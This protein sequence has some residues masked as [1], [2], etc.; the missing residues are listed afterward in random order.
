M[1]NPVLKS[2]A[3]FIP[4]LAALVLFIS[5]AVESFAGSLFMVGGWI[6]G[7]TGEHKAYVYIYSNESDY[8]N[9]IAAKSF[10][11]FPE[12]VKESKAQY[13]FSMS[14]GEY[15]IHVFEDKNG[16]KKLNRGGYFNSPSEPYGY[17][18][19]YRPFLSS[20]SF[21]KLK[22]KLDREIKN[23]NINLIKN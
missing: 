23:A 11:I 20:P 15:L 16:D 13:R 22:F 8:K 4:L 2:F 6:R 21:E 10:I 14:A 9:G 7:L 12:N 3:F 5:C 19:R 1:K 18:K 17:Y